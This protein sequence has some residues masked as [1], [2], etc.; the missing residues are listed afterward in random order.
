MRHHGGV[1][2]LNPEPGA[3]G[4]ADAGAPAQPVAADVLAPAVL[5]GSPQPLPAD[6]GHAATGPGPDPVPVLE[7]VRPLDTGGAVPTATRRQN[8]AAIVGTVVLVVAI[9]FGGGFA[10]GRF[11]APTPESGTAVATQAPAAT[12]SASGEPG[13][14][15]EAGATADPGVTPVPSAG[16]DLPSDGARLGSAD[17]PVVI[18]YWADYQCPFCSKFAL[19]VIP[20]LYPYIEDGTVQLI[21]RDFAFIG[22]ESMQSAIAV[23]CAADEGKYWQ[24]HDAVYAAQAGENQGAFSDDK[25]TAIATSIGLDTGA[26]ETCLADRDMRIAVMEDTAA[27][28]RVGVDSTPTVDVNGARISAPEAGKIEDA[29]AAAVA[30]ATPAPAPTQRPTG[31]PWGALDLRGREAGAAAA[32]LTVELWM[33]YQSTD[34]KAIAD[35]LEPELRTRVENGSIKV[36]QKDLALLGEESVTAAATVRCMADQ[37]GPAWLMHDVLAV[38][39]QGAGSGIFTPDVMLDIAVKLGLDIKAFDAC[40]ADPATAAAVA[41]ESA[42]GTALGLEAGPSVRVLRGGEE[43]ERFIGAIDA[44]AVIKAIDGAR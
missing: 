17:A 29:I 12:A 15:A 33:D 7:P 5:T 24:M 14:S 26:F 25:L 39:A 4:A 34:S 8:A 11:T 13:A 35:V 22:P 20:A 1:N 28:H 30:G 41:D 9:A 44:D 40:T 19:E 10:A 42:Q 18:D 38:N 43:L 32:P 2:D 21:H 23:R 6:A 16:P 31:D 3:D 27:G 37:G 36:V